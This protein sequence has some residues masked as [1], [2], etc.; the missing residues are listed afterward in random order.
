MDRATD[1]GNIFHGKRAQQQGGQ[2]R[3]KDT[4]CPP[5]NVSW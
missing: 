5:W 1:D 3:A 2:F 4:T